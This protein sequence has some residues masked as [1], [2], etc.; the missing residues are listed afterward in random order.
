VLLSGE[1][2]AAWKAEI[3]AREIRLIPGVEEVLNSISIAT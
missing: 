2:D 1:V 3:A